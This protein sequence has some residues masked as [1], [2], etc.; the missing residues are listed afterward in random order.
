MINFPMHQKWESHFFQ[1]FFHEIWLIN[2]EC[3]YNYITEIKLEKSYFVYD[4]RGK[5][6]FE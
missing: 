1:A 6:R 5:I 4:L 3:K 2:K